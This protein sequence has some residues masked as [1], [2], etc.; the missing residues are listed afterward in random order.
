MSELPSP[1]PDRELITGRVSVVITAYNSAR[2]IRRAIES[3][4]TQEWS[5]I[6]I[7][8]VDDGSTDDTA[9]VIRSLEGNI[10]LLELATNHGPAVGRTF[11]LKHADGE[12]VTF[13]D[14][15]DYWLPDFVSATVTF[16]A[17][18][19]TAIAV[20]TGYQVSDWDGTSYKCP[21][22]TPEDQDKYGKRE[23]VILSNLYS[24][25]GRYLNILTGTVMMRTEVARRTGGQRTELILTQ[26]LEFWGYLGTFG[27]WGFINQPLFVTDQTVLTPHERLSKFRRRFNFFQHMNIDQWSARIRPRLPAECETG[28]GKI[29]AHIATTTVIANAYC[30]KVWRAWNLA[31]EWCDRLDGNIGAFLR[32]AHKCG[33]L[34]WPLF[35]LVI[36]IREHCKARFAPLYYMVARSW[37]R[38]D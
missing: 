27:P 37:K 12:Y 15:D 32:L 26:D 8:V 38:R 11:G 10:K 22:L 6:Q 7:I 23:G 36:P 2:Y 29:E 31:T 33:K 17:R 34:T 4:L 35:C 28:F 13:L 1:L 3:A 25:W 9:C 5:D 18:N 20:N 30:L 19:P 14:A 16:L 21:V 24:F